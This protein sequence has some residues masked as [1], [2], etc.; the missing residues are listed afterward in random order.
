LL[1]VYIL[2]DE[3]LFVG[4]IRGALDLHTATKLIELVELK[5]DEVERGFDRVCDLTRLEGIQLTR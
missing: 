5:E 1:D 2:E 4:R 3:S